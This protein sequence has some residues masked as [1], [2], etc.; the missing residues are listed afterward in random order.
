MSDASNRAEQLAISA[1][2]SV[3]SSRGR[4]HSRCCRYDWEAR[5]RRKIAAG[6]ARRLGFL[7]HVQQGQTSAEKHRDLRSNACSS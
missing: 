2:I 3:Y 1:R 6:M 4:P 5:P 7:R